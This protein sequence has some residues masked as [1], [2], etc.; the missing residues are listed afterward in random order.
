MWRKMSAEQQHNALGATEAMFG[1][2][3]RDSNLAVMRG[4]PETPVWIKSRPSKVTADIALLR[5]R[6]VRRQ[7]REASETRQRT[8]ALK[9]CVHVFIETVGVKTKACGKCGHVEFA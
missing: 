1:G 6:I 7:R 9:S 3:S 5:A 4:I 2:E 8:A